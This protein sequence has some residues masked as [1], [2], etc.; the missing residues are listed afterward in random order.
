MSRALQSL[1]PIFISAGGPS[2]V[3]PWP[4]QGRG[5]LLLATISSKI[6]PITKD[7]L[8]CALFQSWWHQA[9][10][11]SPS[12]PLPAVTALPVTSGLQVE[13]RWT[14]PKARSWLQ[15]A[16][17]GAAVLVGAAAFGGNSI[18]LAEV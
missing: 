12:R 10:S 14:P 3:G 7:Q 6:Y 9:S 1:R 13:V 4:Q 16:A 15:T 5:H 18:V 17:A 11:S 8:P 2:Y